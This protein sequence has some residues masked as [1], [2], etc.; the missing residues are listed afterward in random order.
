[1]NLEPLLTLS[2]FPQLCMFLF[3]TVFACDPQSHAARSYWELHSC[4]TRP[5]C[6]SCPFCSNKPK[7]FLMQSTSA[8]KMCPTDSENGTSL[9]A[10]VR[11]LSLWCF[12]FRPVAAVLLIQMCTCRSPILRSR[13]RYD[14]HDQLQP[15][16]SA[17]W[18]LLSP[19]S[20][21]VRRLRPD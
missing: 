5:S 17:F 15:P 7:A 9:E 21:L 3:L 19:C 6:K 11:L 16:T 14:K 2:I 10:R 20:F 12:V 1:M 18:L 4:L 13:L 8:P